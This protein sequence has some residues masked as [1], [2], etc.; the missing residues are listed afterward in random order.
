MSAPDITVFQ[1]IVRPRVVT[2]DM[3]VPIPTQAQVL[4]AGGVDLTVVKDPVAGSWDTF[5]GLV[6]TAGYIR[7]NIAGTTNPILI[8]TL[9]KTVFP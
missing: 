6:A 9:I 7:F 3:G 2:K 4:A 8:P 1:G 5:A